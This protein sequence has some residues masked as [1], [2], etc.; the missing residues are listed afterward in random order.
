MTPKIALITGGAS[1]MGLAVAKS[2]A[3]QGSWHIHLLDI[4]PDRGTEAANGLHPH[5]TFHKVDISNYNDLAAVFQEV[6]QRHRRLD[7][8]FA[9]AGIIER[10]NFFEN[11]PQQKPTDTEQVPPEPK[12]LQ[13][14]SVNLNGV[15]FTSYLA[16][17]YF[18]RSP[19]KGRGCNLVMTASCGGLYPSHYSPLYT[20]TKRG[21]P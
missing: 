8:V 11:L 21:S 2:L 3:A 18:R 1:G 17:H 19:D 4:H 12:G 5:A 9:N 13:V 16:M 6:F 20:A 15:V 10:T 7:F 14:I